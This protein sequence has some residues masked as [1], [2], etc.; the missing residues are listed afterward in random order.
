MK[1]LKGWKLK[2]FAGLALASLSGTLQAQKPGGLDPRIL[3]QGQPQIGPASYRI[4][5]PP[6]GMSG[7]PSMDPSM[8]MP[9]GMGMDPNLPQVPC[10]P[11]G[12]PYGPVEA[13]S[14]ADLSVLL[15]MH[16]DLPSAP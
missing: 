5:G 14:G 8:G 9:M 6:P 12:M 3:G 10:G 1:L 15:G 2:L 7:D 11:D 13:L 16:P 4:P